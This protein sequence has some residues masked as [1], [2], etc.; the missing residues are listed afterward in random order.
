MYDL[1]MP[2]TIAGIGEKYDCETYQV[3]RY[4]KTVYKKRR[5]KKEVTN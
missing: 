1:V 3:Y 4:Y 2:V 5:E